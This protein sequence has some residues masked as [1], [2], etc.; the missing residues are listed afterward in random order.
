MESKDI[1]K[2]RGLAIEAFSAADYA[3]AIKQFTELLKLLPA[4]HTVY[5]NR[6]LS[7][8]QVGDY[9]NALSDIDKAIAITPGEALYYS[10]RASIL[11]KMGKNLDAIAD[12]DTA[13]NLHPEVEF[14][15]NKIIILK[16][17]NQY[18]QALDLIEIVNTQ[19][20]SSF[21][22]TFYKGLL[23]FETNKNNDAREIF[24]S[25]VDGPHHKLAAH[26]LKLIQAK[27]N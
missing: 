11:M 10:S 22:L 23:L 24:H 17:L 5:N 12:L 2:L 27:L 25:L 8:R 13:I 19:G 4:D 15:V 9:Q 26:Y 20:L 16:K 1:E 21:E 14:V 3:G 18:Q 6:A 7:Y